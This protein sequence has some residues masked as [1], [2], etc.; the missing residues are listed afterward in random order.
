MCRSKYAVLA[1]VALLA[2]GNLPAGAGVTI[3]NGSF[4][5]ASVGTGAFSA[6]EL[7]TAPDDW[8]QATANNGQWGAGLVGNGSGYGN[9]NAPDGT[10]ALLLRGYG[11][12]EQ[13]LSGFVIGST[14][15]LSLY[16]EGRTSTGI[17]NPFEVTLGD[18][19]LSFGVHAATGADST[20]ITPIGQAYNFYTS[21]PFTVTSTNPLL[22]I[23]GL[24]GTQADQ[25]DNNSY[26]DLVTVS[27]VQTPEPGS[28]VVWGLV[29]AGGL[30]VAR[31]RRRP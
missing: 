26:V 12:T 8:M 16:A 10:Q 28:L 13:T 31:G 5:A 21:D 15:T 19:G 24:S 6:F 29:I 3:L 30:V 4:E 17:P 7:G 25:I 2:V 22:E 20:T 18:E 27:L 23:L 1:L 11:G 9:T 14:Y